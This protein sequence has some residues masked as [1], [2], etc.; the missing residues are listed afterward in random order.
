MP[1]RNHWIPPTLALTVV[2]LF[3]ACGQSPESG[4]QKFEKAARYEAPKADRE[5]RAQPKH[6]KAEAWAY[7]K[8]AVEQELKSPS[9]AK[10]KGMFDD[11]LSDVTSLSSGR[12][13]VESWVDAQNG[14]GAMIRST[15]VCEIKFPELTASVQ[16]H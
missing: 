7:C 6:T 3:L 15:F 12:Y 14:F 1:R 8:T 4:S 9:T 10:F 5:Q 2:A 11:P 13:R 16:I